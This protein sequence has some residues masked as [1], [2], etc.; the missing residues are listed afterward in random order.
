LTRRK[1][2]LVFAA[3]L[4]LRLS[5]LGLSRT[6]T[7]LTGDQLDYDQI[8][9]HLATGGGFAYNPGVPT[10]IRAPVYPYALAAVY[11]IFGR[12]YGRVRVLQA[13]LGAGVCWLL[14]WLV[15]YEFD[16]RSALAAAGFAVL[17]P[18]FMHYETRLL[19]ESLAV[20]LTLACVP[21]L[22]AYAKTGRLAPLAASAAITAAAAL[23]RP[24]I[25]LLPLA[26]APFLLARRSGGLR[27]AVLYFG[28]YAGLMLP[29]SLRNQ[30]HFGHWAICT[31]GPGMGL[32]T[33]SLMIEG[34]PYREAFNKAEILVHEPRYA[35]PTE[36]TH[37][38]HPY[39]E[40]EARYKAMALPVIKAHPF[41]YAW[42]VAKR[43]PRFWISSHSS[44]FGVDRPLSEYR[45]EGRW[46]PVLF[47]F[48][49][50]GLHAALCALAALGIFV[51]RE[52]WKTLWPLA[53][54][55]AYFT[56]HIGFD[57]IPRYGLPAFPLLF[58]NAGVAA[59]FLFDLWRARAKES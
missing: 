33:T 39:A 23:T 52:R 19:S 4:A 12:N 47:R 49:L 53:V 40:L 25:M 20:F 28:V 26:A 24:G 14:F 18:V 3:A 46:G 38:S 9:H 36:P 59:V 16:D 30:H 54:V 35:E 10:S 29:W 17:Y 51:W 45:A 31:R 8:A 1:G 7:V 37:G 27:A 57:L 11:K 56:I 13:L 6:E 21:G 32:Y 44:V 48:L 50:L 22:I 55:P 41:A 2:L 43:L 5:F 34:M 15:R 42:I 58:A